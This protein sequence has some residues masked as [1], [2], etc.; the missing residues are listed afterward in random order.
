MPSGCRFH[1]RCESATAQCRTVA[2]S[3]QAGGPEG[4]RELACW[5]PSTEVPAVVASFAPSLVPAVAVSAEPQRE[6]LVE[7]VELTKMFATRRGLW[8]ARSEVRALDRV[9]FAIRPGETMG[10][11]G[12]SGCG[13]STLGRVLLRLE[14]P[15]SGHV[16][17]DGRRLDALRGPERRRATQDMQMIFQDPYGSIDP[18]W[19]VH[20]VVAEPL[21]AQRRWKASELRERVEELLAWV[22]LPPR[23]RTQ[24]AHEFSGGQRQRIGIAR[25]IAL[26]P[27]FVVADEAVSALDISVQAQIVNLLTDLRRRLGLTSLFIAHGLDVV[28]H[29]SDRIGV[30]YLGRLVETGPAEAL[31]AHPAHPYSHALIASAPALGNKRRLPLAIPRGEIPSAAAPRSGCHFHPRCPAASE[32]CRSEAP[33]L[34]AL[35]G[36]RFVACHYPRL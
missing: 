25:A 24:Y 5:N 7:A 28:R 12:E 15:D 16:R 36:E 3:L 6:P 2:P 10:L 31:F 22:G 14:Q 32:R 18:R 4:R 23:A 19:T 13:K 9:S 27:R 21:V 20:D 29:I 11:V 34:Q 17:F 26:H 30:M 35:D 1:P 33:A 8:G